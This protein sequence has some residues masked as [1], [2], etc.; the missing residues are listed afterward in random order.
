MVKKETLREFFKET[1][2]PASHDAR[3]ISGQTSGA[4]LV[5]AGTGQ[6]SPDS[7]TDGE[8]KLQAG[9]ILSGN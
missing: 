6:R 4:S 5:L 3:A 9:P 8:T 1:T 2:K 7:H